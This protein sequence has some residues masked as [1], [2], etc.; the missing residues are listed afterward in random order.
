[1]AV[2]GEPEPP[3]PPASAPAV[4]VPKTFAELAL[5][6]KSIIPPV[7]LNEEALPALITYLHPGMQ[8]GSLAKMYAV[9]I[10]PHFGRLS[11]PV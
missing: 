10:E 8:H 4:A 6:G 7:A 2:E 1:M 3:T 9:A 11:L 5:F